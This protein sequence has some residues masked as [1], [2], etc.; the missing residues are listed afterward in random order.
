M[1]KCNIIIDDKEFSFDVEGDFKWGEDKFLYNSENNILSK[2]NFID[3]GYTIENIFSKNEF[4]DLILNIKKNILNIALLSK[5]NFTENFCLENYHHFIKD[6]DDHIK[7][8]S[9]T[10]ALKENDFNCDLD[11]IAKLISKIVG[12]DLSFYNSELKRSHIQLRI[13]RPLSSDF[14][15]PHKDSY[16]DCY[17]DVVNV[18]IPICGCD[19]FSSLPLMPGSHNLNESE[20]YMSEAG[21]AKIDNVSYNVPC[22]LKIKDKV[23]KLIRPNPSICDAIIFS[24][25]LVHGAAFNN[26]IDSTRIALELRLSRK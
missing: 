1:D 3:K 18:W 20:L 24:P 10:R 19:S 11:K 23:F 13:N 16:I 6:N 9:K 22:I 2:T 5:I 14:N 17:K 21:K 25:Y 8:I 12:V 15:P 4:K 26:N 7:I